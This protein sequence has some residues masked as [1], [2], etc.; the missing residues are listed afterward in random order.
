MFSKYIGNEIAKQLM[1]NVTIRPT[2]NKTTG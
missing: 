2:V 1:L